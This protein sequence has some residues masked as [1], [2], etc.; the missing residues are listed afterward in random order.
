MGLLKEYGI[1]KKMIIKYFEKVNMKIGYILNPGA[2][3]SGK[4]NGIRSQAI[5]WSNILKEKG[6]DVTLINTW[7]EYQLDEFDIIHFFGSGPWINDIATN[8]KKRN[9][10]LI[11]SPICDE[12]GGVWI[13]RIKTLIGSSILQ[14]WSKPYLR[15]KALNLFKAIFVRSDYEGSYMKEAYGV[16]YDKI[17]KV[18]LAFPAQKIKKG[19]IEKDDYCLHVSSITQERK[20]VFRLVEAAL[21]YK[22]NLVLA[23][24]TGTISDFEPLRKLIGNAGNIKVLGFVSDEELNEL[25][26]KAKVFALPSIMEGVG[27]VAL[28]AAVNKC[29]IVITNIGGPME[30][31][32]GL[33]HLVDPYSID[34]IGNAIINALNGKSFQPEL[35][36][37]ILNNYSEQ[38]VGDIL[39][40]NYNQVCQRK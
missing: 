35:R 19:E 8:I 15:L 7:E 29:E 33:A 28:E 37:H 30:Y 22:F 38:I 39:V 32:G 16:D 12:V 21:K 17:Y 24:S 31:Y 36:N 18:S 4:S 11:F 13:S 10:N 23:G 40:K 2:L 9:S 27:I 5:S 25:Y 14:V 26:R 6:H 3:V 34:S 1:N 20:N